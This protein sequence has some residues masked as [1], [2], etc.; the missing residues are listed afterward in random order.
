MFY[1]SDRGE[2]LD[3]Y[4]VGPSLGAGGTGVMINDSLSDNL[5]TIL[6]SHVLYKMD[7]L[8]QNLF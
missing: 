7:Q 3:N 6:E 8:K 5:L 2:G 1:H 4:H